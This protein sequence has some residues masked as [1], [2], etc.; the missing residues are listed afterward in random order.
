ME[1]RHLDGNPA[2]NV[3]S[4]L[5]WG[6]CLENKQDMIRHDRSVRGTRNPNAKLGNGEVMAIK[7]LLAAG[8]RGSDVATRFGV[9]HGQICNIRK[10]IRWKHVG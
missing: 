6:T 8:L 5:R 9:S 1:C 3:P 2:N 4:N 10:G 7:I